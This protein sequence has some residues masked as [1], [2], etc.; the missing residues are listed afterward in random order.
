V[1]ID[2]HSLYGEYGYMAKLN[3]DGEC[4]WLKNIGEAARCIT[5]DNEGNINVSGELSSYRTFT[6]GQGPNSVVFD[7]INGWFL[8]QFDSMGNIKWA[9]EGYG[10][11]TDSLKN[12]YG[13]GG[14]GIEKYDEE[15]N[16][17]W[18]RKI[19]GVGLTKFT[20]ALDRNQ[21]L[22]VAGTI[23]AN[24][25]FDHIAITNLHGTNNMFV[26]KYNPEG[27]VQWVTNAEALEGDGYYSFSFGNS[28]TADDKG[29]IWVTGSFSGNVKFGNTIL[30][31]PGGGYEDV[32]VVKIKDNDY[33]E[34]MS[35][36]DVK[37][38]VNFLNI[39]PNPAKGHF[40]IQYTSE[41]PGSIT[42]RIRAITGSVVYE[43]VEQTSPGIS[44]KQ[45]DISKNAPGMYFIEI[46]NGEDR[47]VRKISF[48]R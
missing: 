33:V 31:C 6:I 24:A 23:R 29:N 46:I 17:L 48:V 20:F 9:R 47:Q 35:L 3:S 41:I 28:I 26:A 32:F 42:Y 22:Y 36:E 14:S 11:I 16:L 44:L 18:T 10:L 1:V 4:Q 15:G 12:I 27:V 25:T 39:Y 5:T 43:S 30:S 37:K 8:A 19:T 13:I 40:N 21:N 38:A 2:N 7:S 45:V 34:P